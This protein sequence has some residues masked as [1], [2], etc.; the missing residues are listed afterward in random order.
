MIHVN[1]N[2]Y[3]LRKTLN[4]SSEEVVFN[5]KMSLSELIDVLSEKYGSK[6]KEIMVDSNTGKL[7]LPVFINGAHVVDITHEINDKDNINVISLITGG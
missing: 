2:N 3:F 7:K 1:Y 5:K 4:T 6:F